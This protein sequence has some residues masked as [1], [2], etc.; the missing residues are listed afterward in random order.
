M[1]GTSATGNHYKVAVGARRPRIFFKVARATMS[2]ASVRYRALLPAVVL[3]AAQYRCVV[4]DRADRIRPSDGDVVVI[5]KSLSEAD[6][7][8]ACR[9]SSAGASV[10]LDICD[11]VFVEGYTTKSSVPA[12]RMFTMLAQYAHA[13]TVPT[14]PLRNVVEREIPRALPVYVIPDGLETDTLLVAEAKLLSR[15]V[16]SIFAHVRAMGRSAISRLKFAKTKLWG[17]LFPSEHCGLATQSVPASFASTSQHQIILWFGNYGAPYARFGLSDV[18]LFSDALERIAGERNVQL[19]VISNNKRSFDTFVKPIRMPTHYVEWSQAAVR[20][21]MCRADVVIVPNSLDAFAICKSAN[22]AV[23]ALNSGVPVVASLTPALAPL[24]NAIWT[25][26]PYEGI[27]MYL[28][29]PKARARDTAIGRERVQEKFGTEY[30]LNA[31]QDTIQAVR[32][33]ASGRLAE[34]SV[35]MVFELEQDWDIA[36]PIIDALRD[37]QIGVRALISASLAG[38]GVART[39]AGLERREVEFDVLPRKF[40]AVEAR[41]LLRRAFALV[42]FAETSLPPHLFAFRMT[43]IALAEGIPCF[44]N[45]HGYENVGLTYSDAIH[46]IT[47]I[48]IISNT[49]FVWGSSE[50]LH[51]EIPRDVASRCI[52]VGCP[53]PPKPQCKKIEPLERLAGEVVGIFE[54]LHWHRYS[55]E[56]RRAFL[57]AIESVCG[58]N[59]DITFLVKPHHAGRWLSGRYSGATPAA[60]NLIVADP[61]AEHWNDFTAPSMFSYLLGVVTTPS[62]VALDAARFG[63]PVAVMRFGLTLDR[64]EPLTLI[65]TAND[66]LNFVRGVR[67]MVSREMLV[68]RSEQFVAKVTVA[69]DAAGAI[70]NHIIELASDKLRR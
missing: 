33:R 55:D 11:N 21:W 29:D 64:Y 48:K 4:T 22:R 58:A 14:E 10:I 59:P 67:G 35:I 19:V 36:E 69:G 54:N 27:R 63:L 16:G 60:P 53:K 66:M 43:K 8:I 68:Q 30:I 26:D 49:I 39:R 70:A 62:T 15:E 32:R 45:Q 9:A 40:A 20:E 23:L 3:E 52:P 56:Y 61:T 65:D 44:T 41:F 37:R 7:D 42:T 31:W 24:G 13:V 46:P 12:D 5:V 2:M 47:S 1:D 28:T 6:V 18:A 25:G 50:Y 57:E 51:P 17:R 34:R 38:N